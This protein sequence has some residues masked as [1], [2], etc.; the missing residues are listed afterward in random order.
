MFTGGKNKENP[1]LPHQKTFFFNTFNPEDIENLE[2]ARLRRESCSLG[3]V[4]SLGKTQ[5]QKVIAVGGFQN[6]VQGEYQPICELFNLQ[7]DIWQPSGSLLEN[8]LHPNLVSLG[9]DS[10]LVIGGTQFN[11]VS[12]ERKIVRSSEIIDV[13]NKKTYY[14]QSSHKLPEGLKEVLGVFKL[15]QEIVET[16]Q[17]ATEMDDKRTQNITEK[18]LMIYQN[19][20]SLVE[21]QFLDCTAKM[22]IDATEAV[23]SVAAD[24]KIQ[25]TTQFEVRDN[26]NRKNSEVSEVNDVLQKGYS[27]IKVCQSRNNQNIF[28]FMFYNKQL[29]TECLAIEITPPPTDT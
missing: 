13:V 29:K 11:H 27:L 3:M 7:L 24:P 5:D 25:P 22:S 20:K 18:V 9:D 8:R 12:K 16:E 15:A 17:M 4:G 2:E 28:Y 26:R 19:Q 21:L 14:P 23:F 10:I 1:Q 6:P